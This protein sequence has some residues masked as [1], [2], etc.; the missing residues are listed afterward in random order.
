[1]AGNFAG[2]LVDSVAG[3]LVEGM[4]GKV[5]EIE[6]GVPDSAVDIE[7]VVAE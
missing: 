7:A 1:M 5:A 2:G 4:A 3:L 6:P